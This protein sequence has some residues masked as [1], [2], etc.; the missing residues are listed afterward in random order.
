MEEN[1]DS[2]FFIYYPM[3]LV[4][5]PFV[6]TPDSESWSDP[7]K[8]YEW[9]T[10]YFKDMVRY[11][12]KIVGKIASK[13]NELGIND[14]TILIFTGDNGTDQNIT[15]RTVNGI[16]Q[17]G[18]GK[19]IGTGVHVPFIIHKGNM[20]NKG[21][22]YE[23]LIEF[24]DFYASFAEMNGITAKNDGIS[25]YGLLNGDTITARESVFVHYNPHW[26]RFTPARFVQ[27]VNYKLYDDGNFYDILFDPEEALPLIDEDLSKQEVE[28]RQ[29]LQKELDEAP[30]WVKE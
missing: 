23:N 5:E 19:T 26:G 8:R 21:M 25:F 15:T 17:G 30:E 7:E 2:A 24:S 13:I 22:V 9:D 12:D 20:E 18:K 6:P 11:T 16:V 27:T 1:R 29:R 14:N 4:H 28:I 10:A 3:V